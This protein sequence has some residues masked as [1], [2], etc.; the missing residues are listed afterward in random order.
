MFYGQ[1]IYMKATIEFDDELY[2][3]LKATAAARGQK[4]DDLVTEG[5]R[6]AL[7]P[8]ASIGERR[9]IKLPIMK[10]RKAG[11]LKLTNE[12]IA[13]HESKIDTGQ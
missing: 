12:M 11:T 13:E 7:R 3:E 5:V 8:E 10:S 4:V 1:L 6:M 9:R 2:R